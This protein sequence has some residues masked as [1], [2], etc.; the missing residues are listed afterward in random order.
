MESHFRTRQILSFPN[1]LENQ[2]FKKKTHRT[3]TVAMCMTTALLGFG[4]TFNEVQTLDCIAKNNC[5]SLSCSFQIYIL[6]GCIMCHQ[7]LSQSK[8]SIKMQL[9]DEG[10]CF[11]AVCCLQDTRKLS[12]AGQFSM[13]ICK[14][15]HRKVAPHTLCYSH[16]LELNISN[17]KCVCSFMKY[18]LV[19]S[20]FATTFWTF[21]AGFPNSQADEHQLFS[22]CKGDYDTWGGDTLSLSCLRDTCSHS[23][24]QK[25]TTNQWT[26]THLLENWS[27]QCEL[28][29]SV[30]RYSK[31]HSSHLYWC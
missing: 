31:T 13:C 21:S 16:V 11:T 8:S 17:M 27:T 19:V 4:N 1:K 10:W 9:R 6:S 20:Y 5:N 24:P 23:R 2:I 26:G 29:P 3:F 12:H 15:G 28:C 7:F 14:H 25:D 30:S 18:L 22:K